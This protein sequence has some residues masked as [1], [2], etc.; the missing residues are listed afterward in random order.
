MFEES[1]RKIVR[2]EIRAALR[3]MS[4]GTAAANDDVELLT[5]DEA[6]EVAKVGRDTLRKWVRDGRLEVTGTRQLQRVTRAALRK[7]MAFRAQPQPAS[8]QEAARR[9]LGV[10]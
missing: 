1:I 7:A 10:G 3:E 2:E 9:M 4:V 8:P 6:V 5:M